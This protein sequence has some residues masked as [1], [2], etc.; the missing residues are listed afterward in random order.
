VGALVLS[1]PLS[2]V[3]SRVAPGRRLRRRR[4]FVIPEETRP[5]API[6]ATHRYLR[7]PPPPVDVVDAIVDPLTN[8]LVAALAVARRRAPASVVRERDATIARIVAQGPAA[9]GRAERNLLLA[10]PLALC[11]LHL[12][13]WSDASPRSPWAAARNAP[14][15]PLPRAWQPAK[16]REA[17]TATEAEARTAA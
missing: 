13:V 12:A 16:A 14:D 4:W 5:P 3:T 15:R 7:H 17:A 8:A 11:R 9:L 1:I 6:R 2:V 10:D